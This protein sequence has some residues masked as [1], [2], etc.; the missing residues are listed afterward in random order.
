DIEMLPR[1]QRGDPVEPWDEVKKRKR[2]HRVNGKVIQVDERHFNHWNTD[3]WNLDYGGNGTGLAD[4]A[5]YL[6]PYYMGLY[7]GFI[8]E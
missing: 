5:V 4:G 7:H 6:L 8:K 1:A 2:G 3:P